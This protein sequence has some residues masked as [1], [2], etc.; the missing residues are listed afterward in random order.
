MLDVITGDKD[1]PQWNGPTRDGGEH[2]DFFRGLCL[3]QVAGYPSLL[4]HELGCYNK[5]AFDKLLES[6]FNVQDKFLIV[7]NISGSGKTRLLLEGLV[8]YWGIYF[9]GSHE[10]SSLGSEDLGYVLSRI[11]ENKGFKANPVS[12][13]DLK[14]NE[15]IARRQ[16]FK[17]LLART[18][19]FTHFLNL[20]LNQAPSSE[21]DLRLAWLKIQIHQ[22][23][24]F[25]QDIFCGVMDLLNDSTDDYLDC[26]LTKSLED[27]KDLLVHMF[28]LSASSRRL[29]CIIDE[30]QALA[31]RAPNSFRSR[32]SGSPRSLLRP[33]TEHLRKS[34]ACHNWFM[35]LSGTSNSL[36]IIETTSGSN[37]ARLS[38]LQKLYHL[39]SFVDAS[40]QAAYIRKFVPPA[41]AD[42]LSDFLAR[43]FTWTRGRFRFTATLIELLLVSG[44]RSPHTVLNF[45]IKSLCGGE[46]EPGDAEDLIKAEPPLPGN[47]KDMVVSHGVDVNRFSKS[48][49][50]SKLKKHLPAYMLTGMP[51]P[52]LRV[53]D[54]VLVELGISRFVGLFADVHTDEPL[55][56]IAIITWLEENEP[57]YLHT[58]IMEEALSIS[59]KHNPSEAFFAYAMLQALRSGLP[60]NQILDF[61]IPGNTVLP[62]W[63]YEKAQIV[64]PTHFDHTT[65]RYHTVPYSYSSTNVPKAGKYIDNASELQEWLA[66]QGT[67]YSVTYPT[68]RVGPDF[69][70]LVKLESGRHF[71]VLGQTKVRE[72]DNT[73]VEGDLVGAVQ[74]VM[75][76]NV[77]KNPKMVRLCPSNS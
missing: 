31:T 6:L 1:L 24:F 39:G 20:S 41:L 17:V 10:T 56:L 46:F 25:N 64:V 28:P 44:F 63:T 37:V 48:E 75:P 72:S 2:S 18:S 77:Y 60:L 3:P 27:V 30:A 65:H 4:L 62:L 66:F 19:V 47:L 45:Y 58:R 53:K 13:E 51:L 76:E 71:W 42:S 61:H 38:A 33:L 69:I 57:G 34:L 29:C 14:M 12:E 68:T 7:I 35:Y 54:S 73:I 67:P 36:E 9:V 11:Q 15:A 16:Y 5:E 8:R 59:T 23:S 49:V 40:S 70:C 26:S 22:E 32:T 43:V 21:N 74:S 50:F 55:V 52:V